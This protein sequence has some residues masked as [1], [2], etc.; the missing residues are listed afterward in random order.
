MSSVASI[1]KSRVVNGNLVASIDGQYIKAA[2]NLPQAVPA[3]A[4]VVSI[5]PTTGELAYQAAGG[6]GGLFLPL[7][8]GTMDALPN[9]VISAHTLEDVITIEGTPAGS[10][11]DT[12]IITNTGNDL[13]LQ[14]DPGDGV[15]VDTGQLT[16]T[17]QVRCEIN[18]TTVIQPVGGYTYPNAPEIGLEVKNWNNPTANPQYGCQIENISSASS[19]V[20]GV[21]IDNI[22]AST[23][24]ARGIQMA[25]INGDG[26]AYGVSIDGIN[27]TNSFGAGIVI[28]SVES[29]NNNSF[30]ERILSIGDASVGNTATGIEINSVSQDPAI[31]TSQA[32]G[33]NM[34]NISSANSFG[35]SITNTQG[36]NRTRGISIQNTTATGSFANALDVVG[37]TSTNN[38]A[39][40]LRLLNVFG[41]TA[42]YGV[43]VNNVNNTNP[44]NP[45]YGGFFT[46]GGKAG[47]NVGQLLRLFDGNLGLAVQNTAF[48]INILP[49]EGNLI[50]LNNQAPNPN[51]TLL[52]PSVSGV[53]E[54]GAWFLL[55]K[56]HAGP[57]QITIPPG[58]Q[59][60]AQALG[61]PWVNGGGAFSMTL[62]FH[63][64]NVWYA[65]NI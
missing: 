28:S 22:V 11:L 19:D 20:L 29:A 52:Q 36:N 37:T 4:N 25:N 41:N 40:G 48:G 18:A 39:T 56:T 3:L 34:N 57:H 10:G 45:S 13:N 47:V 5:N 16:I 27:A 7:A 50:L 8:G 51:Q 23:G 60:N 21:N 1:L 42:S 31:L 15:N 62:M 24:E 32:F 61:A 33:I 12:T 49:D 26:R 58:T 46:R 54:D 35:I 17:A 6:G 44:A 14:T 55:V 38:E 64:A 43:N 59:F 63:F 2:T 53:W 9:G 30:G 65:S